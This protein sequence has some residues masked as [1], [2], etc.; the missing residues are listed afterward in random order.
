MSEALLSHE[1]LGPVFRIANQPLIDRRRLTQ[2]RVK[3]S[4]FPS[5][6]S[7]REGRSKERLWGGHRTY[8]L[9]LPNAQDEPRR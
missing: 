1:R 4:E 5:V 9:S 7:G 6:Q 2:R 8:C 3:L